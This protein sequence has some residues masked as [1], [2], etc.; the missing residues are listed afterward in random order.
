MFFFSMGKKGSMNCNCGSQRVSFYSEIH[1]WKENHIPPENSHV[2]C[3][4]GDH[5]KKGRFH[6]QVPPSHFFK[7]S[8]RH[9]FKWGGILIQ[10]IPSVSLKGPALWRQLRWLED[11]ESKELKFLRFLLLMAEIRLTS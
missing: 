7:R 10:E 2:T 3:F 6:Q 8:G 9:S 11:K 5:F 4:Q 1:Y